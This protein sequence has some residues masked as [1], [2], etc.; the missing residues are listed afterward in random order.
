MPVD[1]SPLSS[2]HAHPPQFLRPP[3]GLMAFSHCKHFMVG[4]RSCSS[5]CQ[6]WYLAVQCWNSPFPSA[7]VPSPTPMY[8]LKTNVSCYQGTFLSRWCSFFFRVGHGLL[9]WKACQLLYHVGHPQLLSSPINRWPS[10]RCWASHLAHLHCCQTSEMP[11][12]PRSHINDMEIQAVASAWDDT[13][14]IFVTT[15]ICLLHNSN[16]SPHLFVSFNYIDAIRQL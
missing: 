7:K 3:S 10:H 9:P 12:M 16:N 11:R 1:G 15:T 2:S 5:A 6:P 8:P 13:I 4:C 14:V